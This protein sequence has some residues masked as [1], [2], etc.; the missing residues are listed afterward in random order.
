MNSCVNL[1]Q[2]LS[3]WRDVISENASEKN[4]VRGS[5][6]TNSDKFTNCVV[7]DGKMESV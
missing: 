7:L 6:L 1:N 4:A 5:M 2:I 3:G